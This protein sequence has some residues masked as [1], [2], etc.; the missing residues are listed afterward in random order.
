MRV[1][2]QAYLDGSLDAAARAHAERELRENPAARNELEG[3]KSFVSCVR[4]ACLCEEVPLDRL[5]ALMPAPEPRRSAARTAVPRWTYGLAAAAVLAFAYFKFGMQGPATLPDSLT[6][7]DPVVAAQWASAKLSM[8]VPAIRLG[9]DAPLFFAH[10]YGERCCFDYKV[11]GQAYHVN[12]ERR[13]TQEVDGREVRLETGERAFV[14]RGVKW[15]QGDYF[16]YVV[17]PDPEV[18]LDLANRTS[19]QLQRT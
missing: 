11:N 18:S 12:V 14:Q 8:N 3:L 10:G 6:T 15:S 19:A 5:N 9:E 17:G 4:E 16:L 2:W 1:D 13:G 7:T